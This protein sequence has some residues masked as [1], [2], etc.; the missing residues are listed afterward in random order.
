MDDVERKVEVKLTGRTL[1]VGMLKHL[2][3]CDSQV[4]AFEELAGEANQIMITEEW[5]RA[6]ARTFDWIW[7][8]ER[9]LSLPA[10]RKHAEL[11]RDM[12]KVLPELMETYEGR[13][14]RYAMLWARC[15]IED[16]EPVKFEDEPPAPMQSG[17]EFE[18]GLPTAETE[19]NTK[20]Q[21]GVIGQ[22]A[23]GTEG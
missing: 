1:H 10:Q 19:A 7:G 17:D 16:A 22:E 21:E 9:L 6:N 2:D 5:V 14:D 18:A 12:E 20:P 15:Y 4:G 11:N 13:H 23:T 3:A 8:V